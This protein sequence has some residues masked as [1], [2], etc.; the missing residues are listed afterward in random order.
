[1]CSVKRLLPLFL[2]QKLLKLFTRKLGGV[3]ATDVVY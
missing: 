1:M 2:S 3:P